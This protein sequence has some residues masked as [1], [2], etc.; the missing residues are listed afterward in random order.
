MK[1]IMR[2][3]SFFVLALF[4]ISTVIAQ[5]TTTKTKQKKIYNITDRSGDHLM[6]QIAANF[7][8]GAPDSISSHIKSFNRSANL[9]VMINKPFKSNPQY[10]FAFGAGI[11]T[12]N[13]YFKNMEVGITST[14]PT[15]PFKATD[16]SN[17]FKKYKLTTAYL[18][19][20]VEF[21][22]TSNPETP[23]KSWKVAL[24]AKV[25]T[26]LNA[27]T[28]AKN[29]LTPN[30]GTI[31]EYTQKMGSKSFFNTTRLSAT[32]RVG[33]GNFSLFS[34]FALGNLFKDGVAHPVKPFQIGLCLSGL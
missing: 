17:H 16:S 30:G 32:A 9:Y 33:Y 4:A 22:F 7:W 26:M 23:S 20:P 13:I 11:S 2:K 24:G 29:L 25:G 12:S 14:T 31:N 28:K 18:E 19:I 1:Q 8:P 21:R 5:E 6:F 3:L 27:H 15:L 10:S 34:S